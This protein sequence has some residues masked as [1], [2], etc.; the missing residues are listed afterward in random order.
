MRSAKLATALLAAALVPATVLADDR[1][2]GPEFGFFIPTDSKLR[3]ALGSQWF[4]IGLSTSREGELLRNRLGSNTNFISQSRNG[5]KVF[6]GSYSI[7]L[8]APIG[9]GR[10]GGGTRLYWAAR[11]G[12]SYIDYAIGAGAARESGKRIGYNANAEI[13]ILFTDRLAL[14]ARYDVNSRHDGF[15][16]DGLSLQLRYGIARF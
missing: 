4:S 7:G 8:F 13:G 15:N 1:Y 16:F 9:D 3:D 5:N 6:I 14:S 2:I 11:A 12:V 10:P